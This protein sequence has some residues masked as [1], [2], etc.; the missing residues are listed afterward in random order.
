[1]IRE[2]F[3]EVVP[4]IPAV[5]EVETGDLD[6]LALGADPLKEHDE[7][8]LEEDHGVD[9]GAA[10]WRLAILDPVTDERQVERGVEVAVEVIR[11]NK[12][13]ERDED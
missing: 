10:D 2:R 13:F 5:G 4:H 9:G 1:V 6:E 7:L 11:R 12:G 8:Q 3:V